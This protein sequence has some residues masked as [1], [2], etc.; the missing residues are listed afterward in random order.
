MKPYKSTM[1]LF[2]KLLFSIIFLQFVLFSCS[3]IDPNPKRFEDEI[4][5]F[6]KLDKVNVPEQGRLLFLGSSSIRMWVTAE[7]LYKKYGAI[8]RG[9]GGSH[10]SDVLYYFDR[11][12]TPYNPSKIIFYEGDND[13]SHG[14]STERILDDYRKF[15]KLVGNMNP[16]TRVVFIPAKPSPS[17][18]HLKEQYDD[19]NLSL[20]ALAEAS[21]QWEYLDL[22]SPL[23]NPKGKPNGS[24][25]IGD[26]LHLSTK[27]YEVW[28][29]VMSDYLNK[30]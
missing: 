25:Y 12:V 2:F 19:F 7:K 5:T 22:W 4:T 10:T 17:R 18:W 16:K 14:K 3:Q 9:F 26:S 24:L 23:L 20:L 21:D 30:E 13:I 1:S 6:E 8:N 28:D 29:K 15:L 11:L 27:G